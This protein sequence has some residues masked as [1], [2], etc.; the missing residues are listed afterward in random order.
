MAGQAKSWD[1]LFSILSLTEVNYLIPV[2]EKLTR[3][4]HKVCFVLFHD[5]AKK[6]LSEKNIA[7]YSMHSLKETVPYRK[8]GIDELSDFQSQYGIANTRDLYI[9]EK[10]GYNRNNE[11]ELLKKTIHYL[12]IME[13]ILAENDVKLVMQTTGAFAANQA[14]YYAARKNNIDHVFFEHS[15]FNEM[16]LFLLNTYSCDISNEIMNAPV[17]VEDKIKVENYIRKY[18]EQKFLRA[19]SDNKHLYSDMRLRKIINAENAKKL[20]RKIYHKYISKEKEEYDEIGW[21]IRNN[22][23]KMFHRLLLSRYYVKPRNQN[24]KYIYFPFHVP[25]DTQLLIRSPMFQFQECFIEYLSRSIPFGYRLYVKEHPA[26]VGGYWNH[27]IK[28]LIKNYGNIS[29]IHP[30][31]N[32]YDLIRNASLVVTVNSSVGFEAL[33]QNKK[34]VVVGDAFYKN[35]GV[36]FDVYNLNKLASVVNKA[37]NSCEP[38]RNDVLNFLAKV[39]KWTFPCALFKMEKESCESFYNYL[40]TTNFQRLKIR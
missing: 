30:Q 17:S 14:V 8:L 10:V 19:A 36:T 40:Q 6:L 7:F 26:A 35:R 25:S 11:H 24:D 34:V 2:A 31:V 37:L 29:L 21:V 4:G 5:A 16:T 12:Q 38:D 33:L 15:P 20:K 27:I 3:D 9:R 18:D 13:K 28:K 39:Y 23:T 1:I 22:F 32:S